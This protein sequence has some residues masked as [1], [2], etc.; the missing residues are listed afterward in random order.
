MLSQDQNGKWSNA[1]EDIVEVA[2]HDPRWVECFVDEDRRIRNA[3][4][5][6]LFSCAVL[7][8]HFGSTAIPGL[9]AKPIIDIMLG[10]QRCFLGSDYRG[11]RA[12]R[13]CSLG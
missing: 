9:A 12:A 3:L 13:L 2:P 4:A 11:S 6:S 10:A 1:S 5:P 8:E 7:I